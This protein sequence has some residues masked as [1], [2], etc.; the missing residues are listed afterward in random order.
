[1]NHLIK[2]PLFAVALTLLVYHL[3]QWLYR[4]RQ[5][6]L[7]NPVLVAI[8]AIIVILKAVQVDYP[9]YNQGGRLISFFLGPAVVALGLP[10]YHQLAE[11]RKRGAAIL[12]SIACGSLVGI[13]S[14]AWT[15]R[16][17]GASPVV[18][19][20][21]APKSVTTPIAIGIAEKIGGVTP[22]TAALVIAT[23]VLGAV[24]GP[25]F[26]KRI[27]IRSKTAFGLALGAASHGI[28]TARAM[29]EGELEGASAGLAIGLNGLATAILAPL[30]IGLFL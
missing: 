20:S 15:A 11:I 12:A 9:T 4:R 3:A 13:V 28:G 2:S 7:F 25:V 19:A 10:L 22:L 18:T 27:G 21:L 29:E 5:F 14:A 30:L 1:M 24:V 17:L 26:L 8:T 23:G 6:F 16:L